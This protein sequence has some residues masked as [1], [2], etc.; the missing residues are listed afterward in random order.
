[1][2]T[3]LSTAS[4]AD[5]RTEVFRAIHSHNLKLLA[6]TGAT[7][8]IGS[9]RPRGSVVDEALHL[10][11][12]GALSDAGLFRLLAV[13]T[14]RSIFPDRRIGH[15]REGW[16]ASFLV[17]AGDPTRDLSHIRDVRLKVKRGLV[18]P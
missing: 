10:R 9:D 1:M 18:I 2:V 7:L 16:E 13:Q 17:L 4:E 8:A 14:P 11:T 3:T 15:L 5:S 6:E 12:L